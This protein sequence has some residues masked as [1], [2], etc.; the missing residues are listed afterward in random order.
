MKFR[1]TDEMHEFSF[2][3][4][5]IQEL[6]IQEGR[7]VFTF[8]GA[9]VRAKNSQ[10]ARFQDMYC[11]TIVLQLEGAAVARLVKEGMKYYDA[12]GN[13]Q[14]EIPDEDV[15]APAQPEILRRLGK[16]TVFTAVEDKM[17]EGYAYEFGIDVPRMEDGEEVDTYW[18]CIR[19]RH[20]V[21]MWDRYASPAE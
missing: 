17:E 12:D 8:N 5:V 15:P 19:F 20:S 1:S 6:Q 11:N 3:D 9:L 4:S 21:A 13:L 18:L 14:K 10:N 2:D 7:I 16:G